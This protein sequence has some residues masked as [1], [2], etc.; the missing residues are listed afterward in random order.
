M[1]LINCPECG[2]EISDQA[3]ACP[4]C[5]FSLQKTDPTK[6]SVNVNN[7]PSIKCPKCKSSNLQAISDTHGKGASFWKLCCC[8]FL[9]LCGTGKTT[10]DHYWVCQ[11]CGNKF[12][13]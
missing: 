12:R 8:G 1:S 10:T 7:S 3:A 5:G 9:G 13:M 2:K 11:D 4:N 6:I